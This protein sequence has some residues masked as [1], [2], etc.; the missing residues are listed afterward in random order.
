V[1]LISAPRRVRSFRGW[2]WLSCVRYWD[3]GR[4]RTYALFLNG[5]SVVEGRYAN[6]TDECGSQAYDSFGQMGGSFGLD[7]L[8]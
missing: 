8:H 2:D 4:R 1:K 7:P 3:A 6:Q 5:N